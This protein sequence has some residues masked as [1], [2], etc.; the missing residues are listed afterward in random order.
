V[1]SWLVTGKSL[2][3]FTVYLLTFL[4]VIY[5]HNVRLR[6][7]DQQHGENHVIFDQI[8]YNAHVILFN[9]RLC[10]STVLE[11]LLFHGNVLL[12][13]SNALCFTNTDNIY[14]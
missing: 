3:L 1:T 13:D 8:R 12:E 6:S 5:L 2:N 7:P 4:L 14:I 11:T 9:I 10:S